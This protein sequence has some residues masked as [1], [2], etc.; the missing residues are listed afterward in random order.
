MGAAQLR[1]MLH[2]AVSARAESRT[3]AATRPDGAAQAVRKGSGARRCVRVHVC[4]LRPWLLRR[5]GRVRC[6]CC[7][8]EVWA[9]RPETHRA[10]RAQSS[11]A[12]AEAQRGGDVS[13]CTQGQGQRMQHS[14]GEA[15]PLFLDHGN[16]PGSGRRDKRAAPSFCK[17][18]Q[19]PDVGAARKPAASYSFSRRLISAQC[20]LGMD[21]PEPPPEPRLALLCHMTPELQRTPFPLWELALQPY[22]LIALHSAFMILL[23]YSW[24]WL[25]ARTPCGR[26]LTA[27]CHGFCE[28]AH[29]LNS[30]DSESQLHG[31][32]HHAPRQQGAAGRSGARAA[33]DE[34]LHEHGHTLAAALS[35]GAVAFTLQPAPSFMAMQLAIQAAHCIYIL[36]T[37]HTNQSGWRQYEELYARL[38]NGGG[39]ALLL[40]VFFASVAASRVPKSSLPRGYAYSLN[41]YFVCLCPVLLTHGCLIYVFLPLI[42]LL[43][44][45]AGLGFFPKLLHRAV[46]ML[47]PKLML[48]VAVGGNCISIFLLQ[49]VINYGTQFYGQSMD[50]SNRGGEHANENSV[51][52]SF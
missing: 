51:S 49:S 13:A 26:A 36:A 2:C 48:V 21:P 9:T 35:D 46:E 29:K 52:D 28:P 39:A 11:T 20:R 8:A 18:A 34:I 44:I 27:H 10:G 50:E 3:N 33:V 6:V 17:A 16:S 38:L 41:L 24:N 37:L 1:T 5:V 43:L 19:T 23:S 4:C 45:V 15:R 31:V 47:G 14:R 25:L 30:Q 42:V 40:P 12:E 7:G 32:T 22:W